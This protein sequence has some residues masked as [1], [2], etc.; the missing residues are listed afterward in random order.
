VQQAVRVA[1][2]LL[3]RIQSGTPA[4]RAAA[5]LD[6][7]D[8]LAP[9]DD[10]AGAAALL[11]LAPSVHVEPRA[12]AAEVRALA[13]DLLRRNEDLYR[14]IARL[15]RGSPAA[16]AVALQAP[17]EDVELDPAEGSA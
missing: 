12:L 9:F 10:W 3:R 15:V 5:C 2:S 16:R 7:L 17:S 4:D 1:S 6:V 14:G 8:A 13:N 11:K